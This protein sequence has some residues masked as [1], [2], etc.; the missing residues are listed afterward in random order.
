MRSTSHTVNSSHRKKNVTS[1]PFGVLTV[2]AIIAELDQSCIRVI[3]VNNGVTTRPRDEL[4][5][6]D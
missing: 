5:G 2:G 3:R 4:T 1:W 6:F